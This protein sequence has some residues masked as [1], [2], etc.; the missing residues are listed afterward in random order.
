LFFALA[1]NDP[2]Q[3]KNTHTNEFRQRVSFVFRL[4]YSDVYH[5]IYHLNCDSLDTWI[6]DNLYD[7]T[8]LRRRFWISKHLL[9]MFRTQSHSLLKFME[10]HRE[11]VQKEH[12]SGSPG[13]AL[14]QREVA[15]AIP[16]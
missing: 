12:I 6:R 8:S 9:A 3:K 5:Q 15:K 1:M 13:S 4:A 2:S 14:Y 11:R 16:S 7:A 10:W